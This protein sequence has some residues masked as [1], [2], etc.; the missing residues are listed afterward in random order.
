MLNKRR[1]FSTYS[2]AN[3]P[4][5]AGRNSDFGQ[6]FRLTVANNREAKMRAESIN[7][8]AMA[9]N[10]LN[11]LVCST[12]FPDLRASQASIDKTAI[13]QLKEHNMKKLSVLAIVALL[14]F[15]PSVS[16]A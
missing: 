15:I 2:G 4:Q 1:S 6:I 12:I 3:E 11:D 14:A 5:S 9:S 8:S 16:S 7:G 13:H 10:P